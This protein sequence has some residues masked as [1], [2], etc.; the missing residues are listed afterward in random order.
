MFPTT[1]AITAQNLKL[2]D[3]QIQ[4]K[5][6]RTLRSSRDTLRPN[7]TKAKYKTRLQFYSKES[8]YSIYIPH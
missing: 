7:T 4:H 8:K 5:D 2:P 1:H 6:S 3:F